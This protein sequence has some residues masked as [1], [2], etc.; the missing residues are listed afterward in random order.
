[1]TSSRWA[2]L[3]QMQ[4]PRQP[5]MGSD[6]AAWVVDQWCSRMSVFRAVAVLGWLPVQPY[7]EGHRPG[8]QKE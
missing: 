8:A 4:Q 1:M 3:V 2:A 7:T 5:T 6:C